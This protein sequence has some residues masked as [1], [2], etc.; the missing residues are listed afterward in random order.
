MLGIPLLLPLESPQRLAVSL[1]LPLCLLQGLR[2]HIQTL[3]V[4]LACWVTSDKSL[5]LS[6]PRVLQ[7]NC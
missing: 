2:A 7:V 5:A 3:T 4:P 6:E 1:L